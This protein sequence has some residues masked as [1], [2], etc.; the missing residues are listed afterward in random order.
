MPHALL[1]MDYKTHKAGKLL[2]DIPAREVETIE[3]LGLGTEVKDAP[4]K[5][6]QKGKGEKPAE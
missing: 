3:R 4:A 5:A 6:D 2:T 1:S